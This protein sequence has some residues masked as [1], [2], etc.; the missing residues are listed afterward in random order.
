MRIFRNFA[1]ILLAAVSC[2]RESMPPELPVHHVIQ[3]S[4]GEEAPDVKTA[5]NPEND[6]KVLWSP[7]EEVGIFTGTLLEEP[8]LFTGTNATKSASVRFEGDGP[9]SLGTYV[10]VYPYD[11]NTSWALPYVT[12]TLPSSQVGKAG[13][14]ADGMAVMAGTSSTS[15]VVCRHVCSGIRFKVTGAD[16]L[17]VT[18][19]GNNNEKM[20]GRFEFHF[21]EGV[22]V[23]TAGTEEEV[24]LTPVGGG[25]F[26]PGEWY[27]ITCLPIVFSKGIHLRLFRPPEGWGS[28][29]LALSFRLPGPS[30]RTRQIWMLPCLGLRFRPL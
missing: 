15:S 2:S 29:P 12:A 13:S 25:C 30:S 27:Y 17:S 1:A 16:I 23:A 4:A 10:M 9:S 5:V 21:D 18:L 6:T 11:V 8:Y 3:A 22:P 7:Q 19:K 14:F 26:T 20:A 24:V 28:I